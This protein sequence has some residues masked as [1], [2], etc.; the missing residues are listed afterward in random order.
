ME[1]KTKVLFGFSVFNEAGFRTQF[2]ISSD[3]AVYEFCNQDLRTSNEQPFPAL[4][5]GQ[6]DGGEW[7]TSEQELVVDVHGGTS[8]W[9]VL[10]AFSLLLIAIAVHMRHF[11]FSGAHVTRG[12]DQDIAFS[13]VPAID[14]YIPQV[15]SP[16]MA[17]PLILCDIKDIDKRLFNWEDDEHPHSEYDVTG[18]IAEILGTTSFTEVFAQVKYWPQK[19]STVEAQD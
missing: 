15:S 7:M 14:S 16:M 1:S 13:N 8:L 2:N 11:F 12:E 6:P 5:S 4:S 19:T 10:L 18:D 3:T 9:F 17:F